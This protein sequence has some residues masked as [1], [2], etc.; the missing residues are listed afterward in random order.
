M[1]TANV[2]L[3]QTGAYSEGGIFSDQDLNIFPAITGTSTAVT[4]SCD[5]SWEIDGGGAEY[6]RV[7]GNDSINGDFSI[8]FNDTTG[9]GSGTAFATEKATMDLSTLDIKTQVSAVFF[10]FMYITTVY[11][12]YTP[13]AGGP[14]VTTVW[15]RAHIINQ[16]I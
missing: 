10:G 6:C 5:Y 4:I 16:L 13:A 7:D 15:H 3:N 11:A 2:V 8:F 12:T 1:A 14:P 9:T